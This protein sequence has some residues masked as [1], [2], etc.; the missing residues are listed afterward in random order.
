MT[1]ISN[2]SIGQMQVKFIAVK[3]LRAHSKFKKLQREKCVVEFLRLQDCDARCAFT[4]Y[5][6]FPEHSGGN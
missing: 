3:V 6:E 5:K 2:G 4:V 1:I